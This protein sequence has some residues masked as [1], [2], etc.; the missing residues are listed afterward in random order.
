MTARAK[1]WI[2]TAGYSAALILPDGRIF[3]AQGSSVRPLY[4]IYTAHRGELAG[5]AAA[6]KVIGRAAASLLCSAGVAQVYA[7]LMSEGGL[8]LLE[9]QGIK[10]DYAR[11][12]PYIE[13]Q[14]G[15]G[16]CP[17]EE[18]VEGIE[19]IE[20]CVARLKAFIESMPQAPKF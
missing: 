1:W 15:D 17:M 19:S 5:A 10:A 3:A 7:F 4:R 20:E 16:M 14:K 6:D 2:E 9:S 8:Q 13:N 11:L 18:A 12:V